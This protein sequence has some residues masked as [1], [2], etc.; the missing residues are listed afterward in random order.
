M[1]KQPMVVLA[2]SGSIAAFKAVEVARLLLKA[3]VRVVPMMTEA[4]RQFLGPATLFGI[5]GEQVHTEMFGHGVAGELHV[6][7]AAEADVVALVPATAELLASLAQGRASDIVR[8]T[9]L[10]AAG[11][12]LV[13]PAMHPRMWAHPATQ[14]NVATLEA[15]GKVE[16]LGPV[17]GEVASGEVGMGRMMDPES[18]AG[19]ILAHCGARDLSGARIVVTAGPT[20]EDLDPARFVSNRSSG[21]M[22]FALAERAA[23]RGAE[24]T[25]IAGPVSLPTP[26]GTRRIDVRSADAMR[27]AL[28]AALG[29]S[30]DRVDALLMAAAVA[31]Y[32]PAASVEV[33]LKRKSKRLE[34][35]LVANRDLLGEV[36]AAR[37]AR[38]PLLIGFALETLKGDALIAAARDKL[39]RKRVDMIVA[40]SAADAFD[41][42]DNL[43][44]LVTRKGVDRL[45]RMP[46]RDLADR[47]LDQVAAVWSKASEPS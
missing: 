40:N 4:A 29:T 27:V 10:C 35:E 39:N 47:I 36:G 24:V 44:M 26:F 31:D 15:D 7:L 12:V 21:K 20:V 13:A 6:D 17:E 3:G 2:V 23:A 46:K 41:K 37:A 1:T 19:A 5:C 28:W 32:R 25:L 38:R 22:G 43:A 18:L 33:K 16:L 42:D 8:A 30:L 34:I 14:R 11:P 45:D 9:A